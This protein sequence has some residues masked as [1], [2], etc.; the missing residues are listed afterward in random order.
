MN[1]KYV[2]G[3]KN[4]LIY[5]Y[6]IVFNSLQKH[7]WCENIEK[8]RQITYNP[9]EYRNWSHRKYMT[10][11][12]NVLVVFSGWGATSWRGDAEASPQRQATRGKDFSFSVHGWDMN[13]IPADLCCVWLAASSNFMFWKEKIKK[14]NNSKSI[15]K[16]HSDNSASLSIN[17]GF[18][19]QSIIML[20]L[21]WMALL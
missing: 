20:A 9:P 12:V 2:K 4:F 16:A 14:T 15:V 17:C 10:T 21:L 19:I 13:L 3:L 18:L 11:I 6:L 7:Y 8:I 1:S 5:Y